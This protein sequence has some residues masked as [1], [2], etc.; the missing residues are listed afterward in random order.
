MMLPSPLIVINLLFIS[1]LEKPLRLS[2]IGSESFLLGK[3]QSHTSTVRKLLGTRNTL[4]AESPR[5]GEPI[6]ADEEP[7]SAKFQ[8]A[9]VLQR[10]GDHSSA[11][12]EYDTFLKAA[13]QCQI[14]PEMYAEVHVNRGAIYFRTLKDFAMARECFEEA[15]EYREVGRAC[16]NLALLALTEGQKMNA[17]NEE[18]VEKLEEARGYCLRAL[19]LEK[20]GSNDDATAIQSANKL[21]KDIEFMSQ[22]MRRQDKSWE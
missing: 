2:R 17:A 7:L 3:R 5:Y 13:S 9:V 4:N 1:S 12:A 18:A 22:R 21:L 10:S 19:S 6:L 14:P 11:L 8:R 16:I 20:G 15:L